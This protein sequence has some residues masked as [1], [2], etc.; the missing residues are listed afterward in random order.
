MSEVLIIV[1]GGYILLSLI[2]IP[3]Q[4]RYVEQM[5]KL[6]KENE[7]KGISQGE[8]MEGM[9]FEDQV[10]HANVQGSIIFILPN[11][12]ATIIYKIRNRQ[13]SAR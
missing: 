9:K 4:S 5:E 11:I 10:L 2:L 3:F 8:M 6:R 1:V 12:L 7:E 13:K